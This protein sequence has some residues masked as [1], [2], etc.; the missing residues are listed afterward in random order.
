MLHEISVEISMASGFVS[1][2]LCWGGL[3]QDTSSFESSLFVSYIKKKTHI[4]VIVH[5]AIPM[6]HIFHQVGH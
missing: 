6:K 2:H 4:L 3:F 5:L 1:H